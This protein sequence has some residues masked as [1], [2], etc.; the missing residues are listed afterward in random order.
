[1]ILKDFR[2][3]GFGLGPVLVDVVSFH[4]DSSVLACLGMNVIKEFKI[5]ADWDEAHEIWLLLSAR[6]TRKNN[7]FNQEQ[8]GLTIQD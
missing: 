2:L 6:T 4:E 5:T 8:V 3:G 7:S 1:V